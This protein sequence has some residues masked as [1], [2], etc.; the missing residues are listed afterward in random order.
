MALPI[1]GLSAVGSASAW[2]ALVTVGVCVALVGYRARQR[3]LYAIA[4]TVASAGFV[5][6]ALASGATS[7]AWGSIALAA[8][9][10]AAIGDVLLALPG[11][12]M[13]R[14]GL[15]VFAAAHLVFA[16]A[17]AARGIGPWP[18]TT[19]AATA[20]ALAVAGTWLWLA[21]HLSEE[22]R[23][24]VALYLTVLV[25]M[26][27]TGMASAIHSTSPLLAVGIA[28]VAGSD[29]AVARQRFVR[30]SFA[31]KLWGLPVYY[32]G[33]VLIALSL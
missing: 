18:Q 15:V 20:A 16:A 2:I 1:G 6:T 12:R 9:A 33:M 24:A 3:A 13:L 8:L 14:T 26:L 11:S 10:L 23:R 22:W 21:P 27:S 28:L 4:K 25:L 29:V 30:E 19:L 7:S 32:L 17:F 31:N 5:A